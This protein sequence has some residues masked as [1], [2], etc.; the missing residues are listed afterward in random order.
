LVEEVPVADKS[1]WTILVFLN[2]KNSLEPFAFPNF[3]QMTSVG[4]TPEVKLVVEMGRPKKHFTTQFGTWSKTLRFVIEKGKTQPIE[5]DAVADLGATN[6]GDANSLIDYVAWG[7]KTYPSKRTMLVIW[8]HGQGWRAPQDPGGSLPPPPA[9]PHAG[10]RYVSNDD[11]TGDKLYNRAIQDALTSYL[12]GERLDL[13]A[14]DACLMSMIE[15]AYALRG[16]ADVMVGSEELEPGNGWN[17]ASWLKPLTAAK[18]DVAPAELG[19]LLVQGMKAEYGDGDATTLAATDL[20]KVPAL[21]SAVSVF[22][23]AA[24]PHLANDLPAFRAARG[25]CLNYAPGYGLNS[26]D[27]GHYMEQILAGG[28]PAELK[29]CATDVLGALKAAVIENYASKLRKGNFGS[30]GVAIYYPATATAFQNDPDGNGYASD[31]N[32]FP[33]DFVQRESWASFLRQYWKLV[34]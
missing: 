19:R 23:T 27:L 10:H 22:A 3:Q 16:V 20:H 32:V 8:N 13:I 9:T 5:K 7:R 33:V 29:R 17:Y 28:L 24:I 14:F 6:M 11:D 15:T 1:E 26:I 2:A 31:N 21:A 34:P 25:A 18:G 12:A 30:N 4:S